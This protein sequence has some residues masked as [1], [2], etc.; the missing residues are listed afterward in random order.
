VFT[1]RLPVKKR[2][3]PVG[4]SL[5]HV[6]AAARALGTTKPAHTTSSNRALSSGALKL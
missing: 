3:G 6:A 2:H 1:P 5:L 4:A